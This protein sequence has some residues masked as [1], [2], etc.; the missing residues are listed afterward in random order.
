MARSAGAIPPAGGAPE[1]AASG[2]SVHELGRGNCRTPEVEG[3]GRRGHL[4]R[5]L[6]NFRRAKSG[7]RADRRNQRGGSLRLGYRSADRRA[8]C[9]VRS[10]FTRAPEFEA[11][12]RS[13]LGRVLS[14]TD[15]AEGPFVVAAIRKPVGT[16]RDLYLRPGQAFWQQPY[17]AVAGHSCSSPR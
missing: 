8:R 3:G 13:F 5:P 14:M 9:T 17:G 12:S 16:A 6:G 15:R 7:L 2:D 4:G 1:H 10:F 11:K